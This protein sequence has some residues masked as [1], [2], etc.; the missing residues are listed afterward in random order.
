MFICAWGAQMKI[1]GVADSLE[2][3]QPWTTDYGLR[4][5]DVGGVVGTPVVFASLC[6]FS[7]LGA[8]C[9]SGGGPAG[10]W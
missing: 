8:G 6:L 1:E 10:M 3:G 2:C 5:S 7:F 9:E 4:T